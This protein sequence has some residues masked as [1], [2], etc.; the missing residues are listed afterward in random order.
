MRRSSSSS[1]ALQSQPEG[2]LTNRQPAQRIEQTT[3]TKPRWPCSSCGVAIKRGEPIRVTIIPGQ[4]A[5]R[6]EHH[7]A[8]PTGGGLTRT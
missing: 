3:L 8:C 4:G 5:N 6:V 7:P 1:P 2:R